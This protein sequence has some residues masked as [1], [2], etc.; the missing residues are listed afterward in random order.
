MFTAKDRGDVRFV[1]Q[2]NVQPG[3]QSPDA[4]ARR[5]ASLE[6]ANTEKGSTTIP[7]EMRSGYK[8]DAS[9][10]Q[11][12]APNAVRSMET[13]ADSL[14]AKQH[15]DKSWRETMINKE[16]EKH[17]AEEEK[18]KAKFPQPEDGKPPR[19]CC[20]FRCIDCDDARECVSTH[21]VAL[22]ICGSCCFFFGT[23]G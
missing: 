23:A 6:R 18:K 15:T 14:T 16:N 3:R 19:R 20:G 7:K 11:T 5:V 10:V 12:S 2:F 22:A 17:K 9:D 8:Q 1:K 13:G 4:A 21:R